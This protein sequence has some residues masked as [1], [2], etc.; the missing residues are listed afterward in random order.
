MRLW[1]RSSVIQILVLFVLGKKKKGTPNTAHKTP[2]NVV[3]YSLHQLN[4]VQKKYLG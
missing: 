1:F 4:F 2:C 3:L